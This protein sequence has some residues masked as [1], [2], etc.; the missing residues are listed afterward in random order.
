MLQACSPSPW[1]SCQQIL[2]ILADPCGMTQWRSQWLYPLPTLPNFAKANCSFSAVFRHGLCGFPL[3]WQAMQAMQVM[4]SVVDSFC[5]VRRIATC[6]QRW[7]SWGKSSRWSLVNVVGVT[8]L[9]S[10]HIVNTSTRQ[11]WTNWV[12][13]AWDFGGVGH[14]EWDKSLGSFATFDW[15]EFARTRWSMIVWQQDPKND[16]PSLFGAWHSVHRTVESQFI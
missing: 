6:K 11:S 7:G 2:G 10:R 1:C 5:Q 14:S 15:S 13:R 16:R 3:T 8:G 12:N 4:Q 9:N